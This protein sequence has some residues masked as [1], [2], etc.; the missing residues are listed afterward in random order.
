MESQSSVSVA[1]AQNPALG[2]FF[3][4]SGKKLGDKLK[5]ELEVTVNELTPEGAVLGIEALVP[6]GYEVVDD[7]DEKVSAPA[8]YSPAMGAADET[9]PSALASRVKKKV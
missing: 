7:G 2:E 3:S 1:F 9:I 5:L 8:A 6:E 4:E